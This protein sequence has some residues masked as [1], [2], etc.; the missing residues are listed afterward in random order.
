MKF[1]AEDHSSD[2][3][4]VYTGA[5]FDLWNPDAGSYYAWADSEPVLKWLQGKRIKGHRNFKSPHSEFS[6]NH[7]RNRSTL[8]CF[9]ARIVFR[10]ITNRTNQRT[11]IACLIP[12]KVF[13]VH[14]APYLLWPHGDEK[15]EAFLLGVLSSIPLDW[16]ARRFVE[17]HVSYFVFNPLPVPRPNLHNPRDLDLWNRVVKIAGRLACPDDRFAIWA[18]EV[19]VECGSLDAEKKEDMIH[20]LDAVVASLYNLDENQLVHIFETFHEGWDY[21]KRLD[22]VLRH[23]KKWESK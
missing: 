19:G 6:I 3:W 18:K 14:Q 5:S 12:P 15:D 16:Y 9:K 1:E 13:V 2:D 17:T 4:P 21:Q 10:D 8:P 20:E 7:V 23:F 22:G 11:I